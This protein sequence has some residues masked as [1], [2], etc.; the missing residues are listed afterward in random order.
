[1]HSRRS[2]LRGLAQGLLATAVAVKLG[3]EPVPDG[4]KEELTMEKLKEVKLQINPHWENAAYE[5][6]YIRFD[7]VN[8][9]WVMR[10]EYQPP[11]P[12]EADGPY[13]LDEKTGEYVKRDLRKEF[14]DQGFDMLPTRTVRYTY[15][16]VLA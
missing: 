13:F 15:A 7:W 2:F 11:E 12:A 1:M 14:L 16:G 4:L 8:E 9:E 3:A 6:Q 5:C 10:S